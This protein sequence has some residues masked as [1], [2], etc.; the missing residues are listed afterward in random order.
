MP[1]PAKASEAEVRFEE[2]GA[3]DTR[4][5]LDHRGFSRH[6]DGAEDYKQMMS[7]QGWPYAL[8]GYVEAATRWASGPPEG[9]QLV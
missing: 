4:V 2:A 6:G 8:E 9:G 1:D 7:E 3:R 5:E